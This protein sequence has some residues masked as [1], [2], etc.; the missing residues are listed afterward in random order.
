MK[1]FSFIALSLALV[2][3]IHGDLVFRKISSHV[4]M[5][6]HKDLSFVP[7]A[8][9]TKYG[10]QSAPMAVYESADQDVKLVAR[11]IQEAVDSNA[12]PMYKNQDANKSGGKDIKLESMFRK[13]ALASQFDNIK[14]HQDTIKEIE[15]NKFIVYEYTATASGVDSKGEKTVT[16]SYAYYQICFIKNKTYIFNFYCPEDRR[17]EW[18]SSAAQMMN[19]IKIR[20]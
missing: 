11:L 7:M 8:A 16:T 13:S 1:K 4:S 6:V 12:K 10:Q 2:S 17:E 19:S 15:G 9:Q 20:K 3:F 14:F 18:K 5:S